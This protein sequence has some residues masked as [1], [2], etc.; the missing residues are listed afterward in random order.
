M[1]YSLSAVVRS[2]SCSFSSVQIVQNDVGEETMFSD[3]ESDIG[4]DIT[5][6]LCTFIFQKKHAG[7]YVIA[8]NFRV[9]SDVFLL[10]S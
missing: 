9:Y 7:Y 5:D 4:D 1:T 6:A 10:L 8:H 2:I 3:D